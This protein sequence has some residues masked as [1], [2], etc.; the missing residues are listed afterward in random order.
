VNFV[1]SKK[2]FN[3]KNHQTHRHVSI[4]LYRFV[5]GHRQPASPGSFSGEKTDISAYFKP[6]QEFYSKDEGFRQ[7]VVKQE[8][9]LV[10]AWLEVEPFA[11]GPIKHI[12]DTFGELFEVENGELTI[13]VNGQF[14]KLHPGEKVFIPRGTPHKP[15]NE[16]AETIR[17]RGSFAFPEKFAFGLAQIYGYAEEHPNLKVSPETLL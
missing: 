16:T 8:S 5:F 7:H 13:W 3:E 12:H 11:P 2:Q 10:H 6:G 9:G 15:Y 17:V 1:L 4:D 14:K